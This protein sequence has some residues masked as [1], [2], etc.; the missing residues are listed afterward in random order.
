MARTDWTNGEVSATN[1]VQIKVGNPTA[2]S[3]TP[4]AC[5]VRYRIVR[6]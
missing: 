3:I 5:V 6:A 2:G 1:Q 4:A